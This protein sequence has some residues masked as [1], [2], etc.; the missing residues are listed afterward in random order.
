M[1]RNEMSRLF[2]LVAIVVLL[3]AAGSSAGAEQH[4]RAG[5][6]RVNISPELPIWLSGYGGRNK[7][8]NSK[9]DDLWA[10]ALVLEDAAGHR[11]AL[12]TMDLVGV[13]RELSQEVCRDIEARYKLPRAAV[14]LCTSHTHSGPVIRGNLMPM[15]N[16]DEDQ[17]RRIVEYKKQLV[18]NIVKTVGEAIE[19]LAP[20][21]LKW[22]VGAAE[23]AI[24]RRNNKEGEIVKLREQNQLVGPVDHDVPVLALR[25]LAR[26]RPARTRKTPSGRR[27]PF[28][29]RLRRRSESAPAAHNPVDGKIRRRIC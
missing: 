29:G 15:Y 12:V 7:P 14:S 23:F 17:S 2:Q 21:Q 26:R 16:L 18:D 10:K 11:A 3:A 22:G 9:N 25:R 8:A 5:V 6:A 1:E 13:D 20:A 4:W 27:R 19:S 28:L 24:N